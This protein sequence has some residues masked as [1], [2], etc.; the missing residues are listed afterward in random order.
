M[1]N[2]RANKN[3]NYRLPCQKV[4]S[5][6][7][8]VLVTFIISACNDKPSDTYSEYQ[9]RLASTTAVE[10]PSASQL[11]N[12]DI[13]Y[14]NDN[15]D[16]Q[17][18]SLLQLAQLNHCPLNGLIAA[19][20]NQLGKVATVSSKLIYQIR[21]IQLTNKCMATIEDKPKIYQALQ[22]ATANKKAQLNANFKALLY[23]EPELKRTW[24]LGSYE[25]DESLSG[26]VETEQALQQLVNIK[27]AITAKD[28]QNIDSEL[29]FPALEVLNK[30]N[31]NQALISSAR[32]QIKLNNDTRVYLQN[33][34]L[35]RF[36][37]PNKNKQ[38]AK[39][40]SNIFKKYYLS[41]LQP[42][43]AQ[44]T[45]ALERLMPLY[46]ALWLTPPQSPPSALHSFIN[47]SPDNLLYSLKSSAKAHVKWW[48]VFYKTCE[49]SPI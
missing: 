7:V 45:S 48:Q 24:L 18:I 8:W 37:A 41:Q 1:L 19:H 2:K 47:D 5:V 11:R 29:L 3:H 31:F 38:K 33:L 26:L 27:K 43:Q 30:F 14:F 39:I 23:Q 10:L 4:A 35:K 22:N 15:I 25:V 36:C 42:Y 44:L 32:R 13:N 28:Y 17:T 6:L 46:K 49:I 34:K 20:N 9:Q 16:K 12:I 40:L 21:F